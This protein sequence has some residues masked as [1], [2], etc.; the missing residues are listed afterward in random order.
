MA[1]GQTFAVIIKFP[2]IV[3][4]NIHLADVAEVALNSVLRLLTLRSIEII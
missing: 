2:V 3:S 1:H 4:V